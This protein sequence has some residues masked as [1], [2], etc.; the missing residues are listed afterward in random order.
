M[1]V[2]HGAL[3]ANLLRWLENL[4]DEGNNVQK[5]RFQV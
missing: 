1:R 2:K 3:G 4:I 5:G